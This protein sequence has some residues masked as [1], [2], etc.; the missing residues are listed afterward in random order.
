MQPQD[1][2][3]P[4]QQPRDPYHPQQQPPYAQPPY[5]QTFSERPPKKRHPL[6][7]I[8]VLIVG[9]VAGGI[10]FA[11]LAVSNSP[12]KTTSQNYYDA[13]KS[14]DYASA[15]SYLDPTITLSVQGQ[16]Q[17][18]SQQSFIQV[19]QA[20]DAAKGKV[21]NYSIT[22]INL[23]ASTDTGNTASITVSV[24]RNTTYVVHLQLKQEGNDWKIVGFD[25]L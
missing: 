9:V 7:W 19:A 1:P 3:H 22:G 23:N 18:I 24:T 25:S 2:Y 21:S 6:L 15:Y 11:V 20:Y 17:Q 12:A 5:G 4:W 13:F 10:V 14:Q 8:L 16:K